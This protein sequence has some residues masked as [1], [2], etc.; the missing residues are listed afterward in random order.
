M[1]YTRR[2][3]LRFA[4]AGAFVTGLPLFLRDAAHAEEVPRPPASASQGPGKATT[5]LPA[6]EG[7]ERS[8]AE[9]VHNRIVEQEIK[10]ADE[11]PEEVKKQAEERGQRLKEELPEPAKAGVAH[12]PRS[13]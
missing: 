1:D 12:E 11:D 5:V 9:E 4:A 8:K 7:Y 3:A 2:E 13:E 10:K 6:K